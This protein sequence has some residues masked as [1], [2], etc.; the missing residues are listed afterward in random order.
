MTPDHPG[1]NPQN[2]GETAGTPAASYLEEQLLS[3]AYRVTRES[4]R[5]R[6]RMLGDDGY[7]VMERARAHRWSAIPSWADATAGISVRGRSSVTYHRTTGE[8][9]ELA[10]YEPDARAGLGQGRYPRRDYTGA[11]CPAARRPRAAVLLDCLTGGRT[12]WV[13]A[14]DPAA[15]FLAVCRGGIRATCRASP[16]G[17]F[18]R[19]IARGH[20]AGRGALRRAHSPTTPRAQTRRKAVRLTLFAENLLTTFRHR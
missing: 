3:T 4:F 5:D 17:G 20:A 16:P 1:T 10:Y 6:A 2:A 13:A 8:A 11:E 7:D 12:R 14:R 9:Y 15:V 18:R 19:R